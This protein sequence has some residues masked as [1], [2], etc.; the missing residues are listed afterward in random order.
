[1]INERIV[2]FDFLL[3]TE[4][5]LDFEYYSLSRKLQIKFKS[6][7]LELKKSYSFKK[8]IS[9]SNL[10][11][12]NFI[13]HKM[14][15]LFFTDNENLVKIFEDYKIIYENLEQKKKEFFDNN[16][17][18][19]FHPTNGFL[20]FT[21]LFYLIKIKNNAF[22]SKEIS[23]RALF[24]SF[25]KRQI[26]TI[27]KLEKYANAYKIILDKVKNKCICEINSFIDKKS[28][29]FYL[30]NKKYKKNK[31]SLDN[32]F[33]VESNEKILPKEFEGMKDYYI[34]EL[35]NQKNEFN[36]FL[37][38]Y[39]N[40]KKL[41]ECENYENNKKFSFN[42]LIITKER[43][44]FLNNNENETENETIKTLKFN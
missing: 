36:D 18:K 39:Q 24:K 31:I 28:V 4:Q 25:N 27:D 12:L 3:P 2:T 10:C 9:E 29:K 15:I 30:N 35:I 1:M 6:H 17:L 33:I 8:N 23:L 13:K 42:K 38:C 11:Y 16:N 40:F 34:K 37:H 7:Y 20:I 26:F 22:Q 19:Y 41:K 44:L 5:E 32:S 14:H 43:E 21:L